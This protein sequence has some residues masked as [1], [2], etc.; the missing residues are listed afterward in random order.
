MK[1][2]LIVE[3]DTYLAQ[4][5]KIKLEALGYEVSLM[6]TGEGVVDFVISNTIDAVI[7]DIVLPKKDGMTVHT[8]LK[9]EERTKHIPVFILSVIEEGN[10]KARLLQDGV[11]DLKSKQEATLEEVVTSLVKLL[12]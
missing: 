12:N 6:E 8:E 10:V 4:L 7:L 9:D 11:S 1:K 2:I 3:D 5:Y